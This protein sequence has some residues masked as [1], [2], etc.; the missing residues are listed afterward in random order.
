MT[1]PSRRCVM[2]NVGGVDQSTSDDDG[3]DAEDVGGKT[4]QRHGF[5]RSMNSL[6][7]EPF[8]IMRSKALNRRVTINVGGVQH[9]VLNI[10]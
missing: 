1:T 8:M 4:L 3:M 5:S 7:P 6:P 10:D 9:E 2:E